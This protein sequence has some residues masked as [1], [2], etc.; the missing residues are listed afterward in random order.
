MAQ[1]QQQ[2]QQLE[3]K[4]VGPAARISNPTSLA[5]VSTTHRERDVVAPIQ[6]KVLRPTQH[7]RVFSLVYDH[8]ALVEL[9]SICIWWSTGEP[10]GEAGEGRGG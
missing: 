3:L 7:D 2:Q 10:P 9:N 1:Q 8:S 4:S 5:M 6:G